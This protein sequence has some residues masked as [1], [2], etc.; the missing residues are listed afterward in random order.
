MSKRGKRKTRREKERKRARS[1]QE[2]AEAVEERGGG[3]S[4]K[5]SN[6]KNLAYIGYAYVH[7]GKI[8][9]HEEIKTIRAEGA[10]KYDSAPP[11]PG[12]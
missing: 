2:E 1:T 9:R 5:I 7:N 8:K 12:A 3:G 10:R 11:L 6:T 4:R